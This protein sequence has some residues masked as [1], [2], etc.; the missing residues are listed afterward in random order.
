MITSAMLDDIMAKVHAANKATEDALIR[1]NPVTRVI[2]KD[3]TLSKPMRYTTAVKKYGPLYYM[4]FTMAERLNAETTTD[5]AEGVMWA[6]EP[7]AP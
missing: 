2:L 3:N 7:S 1:D 4:P 5:S 6:S